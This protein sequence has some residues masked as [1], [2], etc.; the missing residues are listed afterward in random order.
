M[1]DP[2]L[3]AAQIRAWANTLWAIRD[4]QC[5]E[6]ISAIVYDLAKQMRDVAQREDDSR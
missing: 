5:N 2:K 1:T 3:M 6:H 4:K